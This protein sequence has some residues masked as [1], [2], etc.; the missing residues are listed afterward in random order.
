MHYK[1]PKAVPRLIIHGGAGN[2]QPDNMSSEKYRQYREALLTITSQTEEYMYTPIP[3]K[4]GS[5]RDPTAL[6]IAVHAVTLLENNPLFNSGHGAVFTRDGVNELEASIMVSRGAAKRGV[7]VTGLRRV[8]NPILLARKML[9][10][11]DDDL[12]G[13][14]DL[15]WAT[16]SGDGAD[17]PDLDIPSAQGH[18]L[19]HGRSA[20][21]LAEKYGLELVEQGY[22]FTQTRWDEHVRAL[23]R[24]KK[25]PRIHSATWSPDEYLPQGTCGAVALDSDGVLCCATSTGGMTNKLTGRI[26][27]TPSVGAGFWAEEWSEKQKIDSTSSLTGRAAGLLRNFAPDWWRH[28]PT[29]RAIDL[30]TGFVGGL[31]SDCLPPRHY[32]PLAAGEQAATTVKRSVALSGTGNGDSFLRLAAAHA[33][34]S[35]ARWAAIPA[36]EALRRV[37]GRGGDLQQSAGNRW[38]KTGEGEG[39][40]IGIESVVRVVEDEEQADDHQRGSGGSIVVSSQ[41]LQ[42]FNCGGMFRAWIDDEG[43]HVMKIWDHVSDEHDLVRKQARSPRSEKG[44]E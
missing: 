21:I 43:K 34:A 13:K 26:G 24:E 42:D 28:L 38:G 16:A 22:F 9:E 19:I 44:H 3:T 11:G 5:Q 6:E 41:I 15:G 14:S 29:G 4:G 7:G 25:A 32:A 23:E 18:T 10:H 36:A 27:D 20:E 37:A 31:F 40:M 39:G 8:R 2:I 12:A 17:G 35:M 1:T 33:V 30:G